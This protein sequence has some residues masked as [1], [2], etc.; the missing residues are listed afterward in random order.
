MADEMKKWGNSPRFPNFLNY[1]LK[2][3]LTFYECFCR[4][5]VLKHSPFML[6]L[7]MLRPLQWNQELTAVF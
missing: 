4:T 7:W 3:A 2:R 5:L 1:Y 6:T